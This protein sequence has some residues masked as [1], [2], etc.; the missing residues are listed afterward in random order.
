MIAAPDVPREKAL[1]LEPTVERSSLEIWMSPIPMTSA[2][3]D[4]DDARPHYP[5]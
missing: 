4:D 2:T 1:L 3:D 5:R